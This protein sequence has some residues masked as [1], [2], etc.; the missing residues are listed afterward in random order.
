[1]SKTGNVLVLLTKRVLG[2]FAAVLLFLMMIITCADVL[3]RYLLGMPLR[4]AFELTEIILA[5]VIYAILPLVTISGDQIAV[6]LLDGYIPR[7]FVPA[8][9]VLVEIL[10]IFLLSLTA[11]A[12]ASKADALLRSNLV[13]DIIRI[14]MGYVALLMSIFCAVAAILLVVT[15][16]SDLRSARFDAI[17]NNL[18]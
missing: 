15:R 5:L 2:G 4:G 6:D 17:K 13:S 14:P 11:W 1:M 7:S 8:Q 9:K 18:E 12:L 10:Q 16:I 3:G